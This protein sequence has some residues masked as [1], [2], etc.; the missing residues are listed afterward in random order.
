MTTYQK[1]ERDKYPDIRLLQGEGPVIIILRNSR[2]THC[3]VKTHRYSRKRR[4]A[5]RSHQAVIDKVGNEKETWEKR[6]R[7]IQ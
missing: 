2:G 1:R 5:Q 6:K 7:P 3:S 4:E